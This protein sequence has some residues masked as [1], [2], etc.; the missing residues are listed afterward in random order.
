M[1]E[2]HAGRACDR[3]RVEFDVWFSERDAARQRRGRPR[4]RPAARAGPRLRRRRR[5][6]AAHHRLR[7]RQGPGARPQQRRADLLRRRRRLLPR[8]AR[9]RVRPVRLH[10][11]RRPPR[12]RR[13]AA[14][15]R[16]AAPATTRTRRSRCSSGS[17]SSC[18][19]DGEELRLSKRAGTIVT[20]DDLVDMVGVDAGRYSLA[21]WSADTPLTLDVAEITRRVERQPGVLRAVRARPHLQ[22]GRATPP[23]VGIGLDV[24]RPEL[25]T[26]PYEADAA[27]RAR[28][29]PAGGG[30]A[31]PSCARRT[32]SR[33][34]SRTSPAPT[35]AGT[36]SAGSSRR[37]TTRSPTSTAPG[38]G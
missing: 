7:R 26:S 36:T 24:F 22:R 19:Q 14:G 38:C 8:Q 15:H 31:R 21:R 4:A 3:F 23:S 20:L 2:R 17:W 16:R 32:A 12:L 30:A 18:V 28:R 11:R 6:V 29:V 35:T 33:A 25:L 34:T 10:A 5:R 27:H 37:A 9:P 13:P 1:L